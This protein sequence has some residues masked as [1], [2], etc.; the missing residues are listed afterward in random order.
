MLTL[1][2]LPSPAAKPV[3]ALAN[4]R[5]GAVAQLSWY[6][7]ALACLLLYRPK[8]TK[9]TATSCVDNLSS[10]NNPLL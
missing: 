8:S 1:L 5:F 7:R 2:R 9:A 10:S 3:S 4:T 6:R